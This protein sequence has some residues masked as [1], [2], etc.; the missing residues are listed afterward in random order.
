MCSDKMRLHFTDYY[1]SHFACTASV[2]Q[3]IGPDK[4]LPL[5]KSEPRSQ[6]N[7]HKF[8]FYLAQVHFYL[9]IVENMQGGYLPLD[10][11]KITD[12]KYSVDQFL[13][14]HILKG[15]L[16]SKKESEGDTFRL[17]LLQ[18]EDPKFIESNR[19]LVETAESLQLPIFFPNQKELTIECI[20]LFT[21]MKNRNN[22]FPF[23][24]WQFQSWNEIFLIHLHSNYPYH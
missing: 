23:Y 6:S 12:M 20:D 13:E 9:S 16:K 4:V 5:L 7:N 15:I 21:T 19:I 17:V 10:L 2:N 24:W 14:S 11:Q 8:F 22:R 1:L 18:E 3:S